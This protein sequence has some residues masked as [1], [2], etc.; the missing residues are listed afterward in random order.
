MRPD[1]CRYA[2]LIEPAEGGSRRAILAAAA[3]VDADTLSPEMRYAWG[4]QVFGAF[5]PDVRLAEFGRSFFRDTGFIAD[6]ER[7]DRQNYRSLDRKFALKELLRLALRRPGELGECGVFRGASA[8]LMA[9][10]IRR[11]EAGKGASGSSILRRL[12]ERR[13]PATAIT[14]GG[15][16]GLRPGRV[17]GNLSAS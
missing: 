1:Q 17:A 7:F 9:A 2:A 12:S 15:E 14:G 11:A 16:H 13:R 5:V 8:F 4:E 10:G 6:Y 3:A